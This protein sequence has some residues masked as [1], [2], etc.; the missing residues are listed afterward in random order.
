MQKLK[1]LSRACPLDKFRFVKL[2]QENGHIFG[3]TG[4]GTNDA[5]AMKQAHV[6]LA[7]AVAQRMKAEEQVDSFVSIREL[8]QWETQPI[9]LA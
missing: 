7:I 2:S 3:V 4:D 6:G 1:I 8:S 5:V 9:I